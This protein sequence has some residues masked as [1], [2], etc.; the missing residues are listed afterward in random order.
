MNAESKLTKGMNSH[1]H[2]SLTRNVGC[3][4]IK[5]LGGGEMCFIYIDR[6]QNQFRVMCN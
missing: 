6:S 1:I 3:G 2:G 5:T 4:H